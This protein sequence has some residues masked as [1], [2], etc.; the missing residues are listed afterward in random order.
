MNHEELISRI[1]LS[2]IPLVQPGDN[3][4]PINSASGC[5]IDYSGKRFILTAAHCVR[6]G[7]WA[8]EEKFVPG[9][10]AK[11]FPIGPMNFLREGNIK[12]KEIKD[13]DFAY[14]TVPGD[15]T[16]LWQEIEPNESIKNE[17][18]RL[19][20]SVEFDIFPDT[21]KK[22]GFS[23]RT[24][25]RIENW[26][27]IPKILIIMDMLYEQTDGEYY[28]FKLPQKHPG[29]KYFKGCSGAP[30]IDSDGKVVALVHGGLRKDSTI[31]GIPL[32]KYKIALDI[33]TGR[34]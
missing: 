29:H 15:L 30:I 34:I 8:I 23:G 16:P 3:L 33:E 28:I 11:L 5:L 31:F 4:L 27:L 26:F 20:C 7:N 2:S 22:Y 6:K 12:T 9:R 32:K 14:A 24:Q 19:V 25:T 18:P 10:G 17:T 21:L 1:K 13:I